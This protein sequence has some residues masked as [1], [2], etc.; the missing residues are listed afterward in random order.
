MTTPPEQAE[1]VRLAMAGLGGHGRTIQQAVASV[2]ALRVVAVYDPDAAEARAAAARFGCAVAPSY[3]ALLARDDVEAVV[4]VTPNHLHRPQ[5]EAALAAGYDVFVEKP[6]A[7]TVADG[8]AMVRAA[9]AT[10]RVLMVGHNMRRGRPARRARALLASGALGRVASIEVHFSSDTA[11]RLP[12]GS[13]R[14]HPGTC[15]L[16]PMMQLGIHGVDLVHYLAGRVETV[17]ARAAALTTGP[18]VVDHVAALLG[19]PDGATATLVSNYCTPVRFAWHV[20]ATEGSLAGTPH[21]LTVTDRSG[22]VLETLDAGDDP[23]GSYVDQM[24]AFARAVR[25]RQRPETDGYAGLQA[26]A[27]VE[28]VEASLARQAAVPVPVYAPDR[29]P[30]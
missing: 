14:L 25:T 29:H 28:A 18:P 27:V 17:Q 2:P 5:A 13:W 9:E 16:L 4:L 1:P 7:N 6:L 12:A 24:A 10:G 3:E 11:Q 15:P 20:A 23:Y 22:A 19:L 21:T 8:R 26:L 30:A